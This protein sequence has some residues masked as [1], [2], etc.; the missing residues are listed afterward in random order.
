MKHIPVL[1]DEVI[2]NLDIKSDGIYIDG[3]VGRGGHSLEIAKRLKDGHL[4]C[5]DKD[6]V[7]IKESKEVLKDYLDKVTFI[8]D[9]FKNI[10]N[11]EIKEIDGYLLDLGV[12]SPQ[13][14]DEKRGFS[15]RFDSRLDMRM[16]LSQNK[17][18]YIVINEYEYKDLVRIFYEY[19][20]EKYSKNIAKNIIEKRTVKPIETTFELVDIIKESLP[21]KE[22]SK[23][24]HPAKKVFQALRI[25][26]NN[27][28][29]GLKEA[30]AYLSKLLKIGGRGMII[31]FHSLEDRIIKQEFVYLSNTHENK[32]MPEL[33]ENIKAP[34]F[35]LVNKKPILANSLELE[36]N[37]RSHSAKLRVIERVG[38]NYE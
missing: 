24:G 33:I 6:E 27:E 10:K 9:D 1:L 3:T 29:I 30:I 34:D 2:E 25:E 16:D 36:S 20:E 5:F 32:K 21:S 31:S 26:V 19:G 12:S 38:K 22:L 7:A 23:K 8:K 18:A 14:D 15:Y 28:L 35:R 4:Y 17:D 37:N 11:Y 13:F